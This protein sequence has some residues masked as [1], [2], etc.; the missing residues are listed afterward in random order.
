[1]FKTEFVTLLKDKIKKIHNRDLVIRFN[2]T[3]EFSCKKEGWGGGKTLKVEVRTGSAL[4]AL[5]LSIHTRL[6][7][8]TSVF[9]SVSLTVLRLQNAI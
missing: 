5:S 4:I 1:M 3:I 9:F 2:D 7:S 8:I 6:I